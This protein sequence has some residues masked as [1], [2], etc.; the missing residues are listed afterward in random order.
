M[1]EEPDLF[2]SLMKD[3]RVEAFERFHKENPHVYKKFCE[4]ALE[5][6]AVRDKFSARTVLHQVRWWTDIK[7]Q[8]PAG[9][10]ICNNWSPFFA[11]LFMRDYPKYEEFF[12]LRGSVADEWI[13][14]FK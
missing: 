8:D 11:R 13:N 9:F 4:F 14:E 1:S 2:C 6:A 5:A 3:P 10:K 12:V 7:T